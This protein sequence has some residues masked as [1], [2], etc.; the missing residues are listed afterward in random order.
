MD[1]NQR[2]AEEI[3]ELVGGTNNI[4]Y[5]THCMTRLRLNLKDESLAD[6]EKVKKIKGVLGVAHSGGQYQ[7]IVGQNV[8]KVYAAVCQ[9]GG[10]AQEKGIEEN[11]D[12]PK[13]KLT[14]KKIGANI[15]N[16]MSGSMTQLIGVMIAAAMFKTVLVVIGPD[17]LNVVTPESDA[18]ILLNAIYNAFYYFLPVFLGYAAAKKLDANIPMGIMMGSM[19]LVPDFVNLVGAQENISIYG[20]LSAPVQS[21]GQTV[22]PVLLEVWLMSIVEKFF[23]KIIPDVLSTIFVPTFTLAIMVPVMFCVCGPIGGVIGN[24]IG[25]ALIGFGNFGGFIAVAVVAALWEF[26]VMS[27]MHGILIMFAITNLMQ[28]GSDSFIFPAG[29]MATWAA[30]GMALGAF[31]KQKNKEEKAESMGYF[32]SGILGG[33]TEPVLFGVGFRYKRP[34]IAL[35]IGGFV[36][37]LYAGLMHVSVHVM[38]ATNFLAVLG[39]VAG[40]TSNLIHGIVASVLSMIVTAAATYII[41]G[42]DEES[43]DEKTAVNEPVLEI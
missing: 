18:S 6:D 36:G 31:L 23:K 37:G 42:F 12:I 15:M 4:S 41:G 39:F 7:I 43:S 28:T 32:V 11:L 8:P 35:L 5:V 13:E 24:I 25:N 20:L 30:F 10:F 27:G 33:V 9:K 3:I 38:G 21:Y 19:L 17:M 14:L 22:L 2:I 16:Y 1:K 34:F 26:L 40:G 29:S